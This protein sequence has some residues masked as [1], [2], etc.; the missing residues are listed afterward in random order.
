MTSTVVGTCIMAA[1]VLAGEGGNIKLKKS[2]KKKGDS[3]E[4]KE[5]ANEN[6]MEVDEAQIT[7][8][9]EDQLVSKPLSLATDG[10][11]CLK[12]LCEAAKLSSRRCVCE[13]REQI[14]QDI[15]TCSDCG[16]SACKR[17]AGQPEHSY[18]P[19]TTSQSRILP[20]NFR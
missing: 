14:A 6:E 7:I 20:R 4:D 9:G 13:G 3:N 10:K 15:L 19:D 2:L 17:C 1:L 16:H 18:I 8:T 12:K 11:A 5:E